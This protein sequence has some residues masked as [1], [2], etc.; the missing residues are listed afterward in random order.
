M[1]GTPARGRRRLA[2]AATV[3]V[4]GMW[5]VLTMVKTLKTLNRHLH[6]YLCECSSVWDAMHMSSELYVAA[7][8][9]MLVHQHS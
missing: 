5:R 9:W 2:T 8:P 7:S 6:T 1:L 4:D 3:A